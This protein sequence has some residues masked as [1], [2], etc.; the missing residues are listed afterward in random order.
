MLAAGM[1]QLLA[2]T[3]AGDFHRQ[4]LLVYAK[5]VELALEVCARGE[6]E[7]GRV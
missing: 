7:G 5:V 6:R 3:D 2:A 1:L 4:C